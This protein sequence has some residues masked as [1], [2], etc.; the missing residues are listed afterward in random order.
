MIDIL[1]ST[2]AGV[3]DVVQ[4]VPPRGQGAARILLLLRAGGADIALLLRAGGAGLALPALLPA[5]AEDL[6]LDRHHLGIKEEILDQGVILLAL[7]ARPEQPLCLSVLP[8]LGPS[9]DPHAI[10]R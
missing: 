8:L 7:V 9:R 5:L 3:S 10:W 4:A 6:V 2:R 1:N